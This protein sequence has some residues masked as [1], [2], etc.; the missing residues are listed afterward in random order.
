M[1]RRNRKGF[2]AVVGA[3]LETGG[4][5]GTEVRAGISVEDHRSRHIK[6]LRR[7]RI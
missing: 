6:S 7:K 4:S 3:E 2:K 1:L 5:T